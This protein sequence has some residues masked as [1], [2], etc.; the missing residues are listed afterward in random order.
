MWRCK[1]R[2]VLFDAPAGTGKTRA[3]LEKANLIALKY[4][5]CRI[6]LC[7]KTRAS[8]TQ[9]VLV[10]FEQDVLP[11]G[12]L[13][14][15]GSKAH[16]SSY[17]YPNGS[18]IVLA[19][20]DSPDRIM[21]C[22]FDFI[23]IFETS[24][25]TEDDFEK[26]STR[27]R[28]GVVPYQQMICDTN[29]TFPG[30]YLWQYY[31]QGK[32]TRIQG[33]HTDNPTV[34]QEYLD[35]LN[36]LEGHRRNRLYLGLW[37]S[38]QGIIYERFDRKKHVK[39]IDINKIKSD[40]TI[41]SLDH[42]Y[43]NP[44]SYH[45]YILADQHIYAL[46]EYYKTEQIETAIIDALTE[47]INK[48]NVD[49]VIADPSAATLIAG[50]QNK[51]IN[52]QKANNDIYSGINTVQK[53]LEEDRLTISPECTKLI[54]EI[55]GYCWAENKEGKQQDKPVKINDHSMDEMR[56]GIMHLDSL[57]SAGDFEVTA[58]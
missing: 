8:L 17:I 43:K 44:C 34:T 51:G 14:S 3:V 47:S 5:G 31:L 42:G 36:K 41:I 10:A 18:E 39:E 53:Y 54:E 26:L 23:A 24:E 35:A 20:L 19:G 13:D 57:I 11:Q 32:M 46:E 1:D 4:D 28:N 56:Y 22:Q 55:E 52:V 33:K 21:S 29:P 45:V 38:A 50:I 12:F 27:L 49:Y 58:I 16:R 2:Y 48:Y 7:R 40:T 9:S 15:R 37:T 30:H 6:L 25:T